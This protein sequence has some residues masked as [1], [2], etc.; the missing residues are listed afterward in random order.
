MRRA[1]IESRK[2]CLAATSEA[3]LEPSVLFTP[4][5]TSSKVGFGICDNQLRYQAINSALA[6]T[7]CM[8]AKAHLGNTVR[9]VLGDVAA[10]IEPAFERVLDRK[11]VV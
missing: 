9:E 11:S 3:V 2:L 4:F 5:F 8:P 6:A 1:R 10:E 7:N